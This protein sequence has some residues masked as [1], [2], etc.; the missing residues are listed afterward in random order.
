MIFL[1][2]H[3]LEM[4]NQ[5]VFMNSRRLCSDDCAKES[6]DLQNEGIEKWQLYQHLP[7]ECD[8]VNARFPTFAYDHVNLRGRTGYG[9]AEGC[10][11]DNFSA[12]RNDPAQLT[13]DRCRVQLFS[14]IFQGCP[15]LKPG[16]PNPEQEMPLIQGT[17][18]ST[19]EGV[20]YPC[21][22]AIMELTTNPFMP[23]LECVQEVQKSEHVVEP[24]IRGGDD[25]RSFVKRQE[26]LKTCNENQFVRGSGA[27]KI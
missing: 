21:K 23:M 10:I 1:L 6:K 5:S 27:R 14:R 26:F 18:S 8:G 13:R 17:G 2:S 9:Q 25:T 7:I 11:V 20:A 16:I 19:L 15:N 22:K 24:W 4:N 3:V 12:L